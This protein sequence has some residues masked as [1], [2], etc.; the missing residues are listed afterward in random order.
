MKAKW[1]ALVLVSIVMTVLISG[2]GSEKKDDGSVEL[3]FFHRFT[4]SPNKEYFEEA[5]KRFEDANEG[6]KINISSAINDDYKQKI[7]VLMGGDNPPDIYF[8]WAGEY[9]NKFARAG[10]AL[11]ISEHIDETNL[12][13]QVIANQLEAYTFD[14][15]VYGIP[16]IMDGKAFF[17]NKEIFEELG[18]EEP[19]NWDEFLSVLEVIKE[20]EYTPIAFGNQSNW[21]VGHYLTT[22]NQRMVDSETLDN[23]YTGDGD[24]ADQG[25]V[26]ALDKLSELNNYFNDMPNAVDDDSAI[27][28]FVN[29]TAAIYYNQ[30]NQFPYIEVG[31]FDIGWF[32]FPAIDGAPG[33]SKELTGSPQGFMVSNKT[34]HP[35]E[36]LK[37]LEF[38]TSE[39]EAQEMVKATGMISSSQGGI[40]EEIASD[41]V[42][43]MVKTIEESSKMNIWMDIA[44]DS[45]VAEVYLNKV[46]EMLSGDV[47]AEEVMKAVQNAK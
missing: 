22:L 27:N 16:I 14:G 10:Q 3:S 11:N 20:S 31:G 41:Y 39:E 34:K 17:Y 7:N 8:T 25:Y 42:I 40:N 33:D 12:A 2:C 28:S 13:D 18:I 44:L 6:V 47:T 46:T 4:D 36:A 43:E 37:F 1:F 24:F 21:A 45:K 29:K 9:S 23:D 26:E 15:S 38:L 5:V 32:N 35:E 19:T 30:F